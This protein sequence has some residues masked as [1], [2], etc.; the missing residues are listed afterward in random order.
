MIEEE[1]RPKNFGRIAAQTAKQV[2][3]QRIRETE[4][5]NAYDEYME[6]KPRCSRAL[7]RGWINRGLSLHRAYKRIPGRQGDSAR[8]DL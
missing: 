4:R 5:S 7:F 8:R 2:V 6:R 1:V 3:V